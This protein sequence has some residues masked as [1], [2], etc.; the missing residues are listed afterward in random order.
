MLPVA[1][2]AGASD[3]DDLLQLFEQAEVSRPAEPRWRAEEI[4]REI[5]GRAGVS[6][7]V[8]EASQRIVA[9]CMLIVAPN[10]LRGGRQ[11]GFIENVV[12]HPNFRGQRYGSAVLSAALERAWQE[13][14]HHVLLQSGRPDPRV[15]AFYQ[16]AGFIAG[17]RTAYV[18]TR[19]A[20]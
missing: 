2:L 11:H 14:C 9:T 10:L 4:W 5:L 13:N 16:K 19:P 20:D 17:L 1:R 15:H 18:A 7:F 6:V 8:S 3:L 12:A